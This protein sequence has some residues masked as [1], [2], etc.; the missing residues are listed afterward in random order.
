[1]NLRI[2]HFGCLH[3]LFWAVVIFLC[4]HFFVINLTS[5]QNLWVRNVSEETIL[6]KSCN[7][8]D[9]EIQGCFQKLKKNESAFFKP[10]RVLYHPKTN[11]FTINLIVNG[12]EYQRKCDF[13]REKTD[14]WEEIGID[15]N[16]LWCEKYCSSPHD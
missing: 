4:F 11:H 14:C 12:K 1:M 3:I 7:L 16:K 2:K 6:I 15:N 9:E 10:T 13:Y 5:S 8:N